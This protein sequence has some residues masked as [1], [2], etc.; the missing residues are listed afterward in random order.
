MAETTSETTSPMRFR[1][2]HYLLIALIVGLGLFNF[3]RARHA[4]T[5]PAAAPSHQ[6]ARENSPVPPQAVAAWAAFDKAAGLRDAPSEQFSP[7]AQDLQHQIDVAQPPSVT[8]DVKGCQTWLL[9]YRQSIVHPS[10]D[11]SWHDRSTKHLST[12]AAQHADVG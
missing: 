1:P 4:R 3:Y 9:F 8:I 12:C 10:R 5:V 2:R 7:A 11:T 6:P